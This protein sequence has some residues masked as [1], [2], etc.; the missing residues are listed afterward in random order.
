MEDH[1]KKNRVALVAVKM[2]S[3]GW[4]PGFE[5]GEILAVRHDN[6]TVSVRSLTDAL[7]V[8]D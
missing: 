1:Q 6:R 7:A 5:N 2:T 3:S 8:R 4:E